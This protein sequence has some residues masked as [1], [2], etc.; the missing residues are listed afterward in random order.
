MYRVGKIN[1]VVGKD[2]RV[3]QPHHRSSDRLRKGSSIDKIGI[4]EVRIPVEIVV[5]RVV[6]ALFVLAAIAQV[7]AGNAEMIEE[8]GEVCARAKRID[9]QIG[10]LAQLLAIVGLCVRD[11]RKM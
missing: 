6:D 7:E 3:G 4:G 8:A 11:L 1:K 10:P 5:D 2:V 9:A